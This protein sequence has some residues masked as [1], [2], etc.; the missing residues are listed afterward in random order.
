VNECPGAQRNDCYGVPKACFK[1]TQKQAVERIMQ[2]KPRCCP[3]CK[4]KLRF[5]ERHAACPIC[6]MKPIVYLKEK[7]PNDYT[8]EEILQ[9]YIDRNPPPDQDCLDCP[10]SSEKE[11]DI[12][13]NRSEDLPECCP[14]K[15]RVC[16]C[17]CKLGKVCA[18]CRV[19][20]ACDVIDLRTWDPDKNR[21]LLTQ[22]VDLD[23]ACDPPPDEEEE[24]RPFLERVFSE[25]KDIYRIDEDKDAICKEKEEKFKKAETL[26][27]SFRPKLGEYQSYNQTSTSC[28]EIKEICRRLRGMQIQS[29]KRSRGTKVQCG[30]RLRGGGIQCVKRKK[31]CTGVFPKPIRTIDYCKSVKPTYK[32]PDCKYKINIPGL[33]RCGKCN[34]LGCLPCKRRKRHPC[35]TIKYDYCSIRR[36]KPENTRHY[37]CYGIKPKIPCTMGWLW[38]SDPASKK[39]WKPGRIS[40]MVKM[41]MKYFLRDFRNDTVIVSRYCYPKEK[42]KPKKRCLLDQQTTLHISK[43]NHEYHVTFK[44]LKDPKDIPTEVEPHRDMRPVC[45]TLTKEPF[46]VELGKLKRCLKDMRFKKCKCRPRTL[47][48]KLNKFSL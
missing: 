42:R 19:R 16:R 10:V 21:R 6:G 17:R 18:Y 11:G 38:T 20:N 5:L 43:K 36:P 24:K 14:C 12:C 48:S 26:K 22:P 39:G 46:K 40:K 13:P 28:K 34:P 7:R 25:M 30:E 4:T 32:V 2:S 23:K 29:G 15:E 41:Y 37:P 1:E 27:Q 44:P 3:I 31:F 8:T 33:P 45:V 9:E 47:N 35:G